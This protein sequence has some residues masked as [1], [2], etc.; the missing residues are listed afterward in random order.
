MSQIKDKVE[1]VL[2]DVEEEL[3]SLRY[4]IGRNNAAIEGA[5]DN[6]KSLCTNMESMKETVEYHEEVLTLLTAQGLNDNIEFE[7]AERAVRVR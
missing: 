2:N 1:L 5:L 6:L 3:I 7:R 4:D